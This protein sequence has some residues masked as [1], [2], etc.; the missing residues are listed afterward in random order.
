M[1]AWPS[2]DV[3]AALRAL[4]RPHQPGVRWTTEDQ[5]H[6]TLRFLGEVADADVPGLVD[7]LAAL[8][9]AEPAEARLGPA[10]ERLG[11]EVLMVPVEGLDELAREVVRV[12]EGYGR[13][14]PPRRPFRGH[15]TLA[16]LR[17]ARSPAAR[18]QPAPLAVDAR[19]PVDEVA[20][21]RSTLTPQGARYATV[22]RVPLGRGGRGQASGEL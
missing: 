7:A 20:L 5:W 8:E 15:L 18:A 13:A 1:A 9:E 6:I 2:A 21:V 22:A 17:P 10:S 14:A 3:V 19:W 16:R 12:T 11:R 4:P